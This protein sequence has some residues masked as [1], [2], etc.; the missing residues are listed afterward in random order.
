MNLDIF[1]GYYSSLDEVLE[2]VPH[3]M[4][5]GFIF[6]RRDDLHTVCLILRRHY[7]EDMKIFEDLIGVELGDDFYETPVGWVGTLYVDL[8]SIGSEKLRIYKSQPHE[9]YISLIG[10]Y[11]DQENKITQTKVYNEIEVDGEQKYSIDY[12]DA[13]GELINNEIESEGTF[14]D[15]NGSRELFD[16]V[17][18]SGLRYVFSKKENKDQAYFGVNLPRIS[19]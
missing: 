10:Y 18:S 6:T 14:E 7:P 13:S 4:I 3:E 11:L 8:E 1:K 2:T 16:V 17:K 15:W 9:Q 12:Y 19:S 5:R